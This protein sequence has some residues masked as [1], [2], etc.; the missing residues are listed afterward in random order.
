MSC[1]CAERRALGDESTDHLQVLPV[2]ADGLAD[3]LLVGKQA[4][5][6]IVPDQGD[7]PRVGYVLVG[8]VAPGGDLEIEA[9]EEE[10]VRAV[11][12]DV[13]IGVAVA[14]VNPAAELLQEQAH[15]AAV[16]EQLRENAWP[17]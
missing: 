7:R 16:L 9:G 15:P 3:R 2:D 14:V 5:T 6:E 10:F 1:D 8:Q 4:I 13:G 17:S 11:E 12:R